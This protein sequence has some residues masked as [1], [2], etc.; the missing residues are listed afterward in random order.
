M[1]RITNERVREARAVAT[2]ARDLA[3]VIQSYLDD[4]DLLHQPAWLRRLERLA[5]RLGAEARRLEDAIY[6]A[7]YYGD[8]QNAPDQGS[9]PPAR[10]GTPAMTATPGLPPSQVKTQPPPRRNY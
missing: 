7:R 3:H 10:T 4:P 9:E 2:V 6:E 1:T 8:K 5:G